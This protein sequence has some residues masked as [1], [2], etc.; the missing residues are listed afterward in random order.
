M[1]QWVRDYQLRALEHGLVQETSAEQF[2]R[3]FDWAGLQRNLKNIG[4]FIRL[5][6]RDGKPGYMPHIP[7]ILGYA[8]Y[9]AAKYPELSFLHEILL[10][11]DGQGVGL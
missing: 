2:M 5:N 9:I 10:R 8:R 6:L 11:V 4:L 7:R 3:W 1:Q